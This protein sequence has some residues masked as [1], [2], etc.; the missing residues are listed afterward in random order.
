MLVL[1]A[2][3]AGLTHLACC[4][5]FADEN[6]YSSVD[7]NELGTVTQWVVY[8]WTHNG[9]APPLTQELGC[10]LGVRLGVASIWALTFVQIVFLLQQ[11][12]FCAIA[13]GMWGWNRSWNATLQ[14]DGNVMMRNYRR[15][16]TNAN[17]F[18]AYGNMS[19]GQ[20]KWL[21]LVSLLT[22]LGTFLTA[23][24]SLGELIY[25]YIV[26]MSYIVKPLFMIVEH[27]LRVVG[28]Y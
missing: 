18:I 1:M 6:N 15:C 17:E 4:I 14:N 10:M 22:L 24:L 28:Y 20:Q 23:I 3:T 16:K 5:T 19:T 27:L 25:A 7:P 9:R 13:Y 26:A 11:L 8:L 2:G 21:L 12:E